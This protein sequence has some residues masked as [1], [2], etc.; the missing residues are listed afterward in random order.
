MNASKAKG[1]R[2]ETKVAR[3]L[4]ARG[5]EAERKPLKGNRDEGDLDLFLPTTRL[6][7]EVKAGKQT[8]NP[9]RSQLVEWLRQAEVEGKNAGVQC[10]LVIVRYNRLLCDAEVWSTEWQMEYL[11]DFA[12][13]AGDGTCPLIRGQTKS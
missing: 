1:T 8:A 6:V 10:L 13:K 11:D 5:L 12:R 4:Q 2:A 7:L 9:H 3:F